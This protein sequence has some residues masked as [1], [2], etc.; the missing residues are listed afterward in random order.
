ML[1]LCSES[2]AK[3]L[4]ITPLGYIKDFAYAG[5]EAHKMGLGPIYATQKLFDKTHL[6]LKD[7]D[8]IEM[9]E[10]FAA[11][12]LANIK[13]FDSETFCQKT[14]T[15]I[16]NQLTNCPK[17]GKIITEIRKG[18]VFMWGDIAIAFL[19]AFITAYVVT[20]YTIRFAKKMKCI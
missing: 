14:F 1:S 15:Y 4:G 5:L 18:S 9:N 20:P 11:Q 16:P 13:A 10:A 6:T 19:L 8:L 3:E 7:I 17:K 2:H 12:V